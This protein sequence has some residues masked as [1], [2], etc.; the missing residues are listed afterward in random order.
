MRMADT[1]PP[2]LVIRTDLDP[3][4]YPESDLE[5][6][7]DN[8]LIGRVL[9]RVRMST[10]LALCV[11]LYRRHTA[12]FGGPLQVVRHRYRMSGPLTELTVQVRSIPGTL[13]PALFVRFDEFGAPGGPWPL[14]RFRAAHGVDVRDLVR[15][16]ELSR[17]YNFNM[18]GYASPDPSPRAV[19]IPRDDEQ[20][21]RE[22]A[23]RLRR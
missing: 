15:L 14:E 18:H 19:L 11:D 9:N 23:S 10:W 2:D 7:C 20:E 1:S 13:A 5:R 16:A 22:I 12:N 3:Q 17:K 21:I 6:L 4:D 8:I